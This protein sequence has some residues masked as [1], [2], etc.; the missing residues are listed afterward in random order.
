MAKKVEKK[1][2]VFYKGFWDLIKELDEKTQISVIKNLCDWV[3]YKKPMGI[4]GFELGIINSF[5]P[6]IKATERRYKAAQRNGKKGGRPPI[7]IKECGVVENPNPQEIKKKLDK[8]GK[9]LVDNPVDN[10]VDNLWITNNQNDNQ[11]HNQKHNQNDNLKGKRNEN[12]NDNQNDNPKIEVKKEVK[13]EVEVKKEKEKKEKEKKDF[14]KNEKTANGKSFLGPGG[15]TPNDTTTANSPNDT[16]T[17]DD[18][19]ATDFI[20]STSVDTYK[21]RVD[22]ASSL[23][24]DII[25]AKLICNF[26]QSEK[27]PLLEYHYRAFIGLNSDQ[28]KVAFESLKSSADVLKKSLGRQP[29]KPYDNFKHRR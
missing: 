5:L 8:Q 28:A 17:T 22:Y 20:S 23:G 18:K 2:F 10:P 25:V 21:Q 19:T 1:A 4:N 15:T 16:A 12:Q 11:K 14:S 24:I 26:A 7:S 9:P 27:F 6:Q 29:F 13:K 3:F